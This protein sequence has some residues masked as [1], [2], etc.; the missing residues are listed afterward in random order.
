[1]AR[2]T[3]KSYPVV[4]RDVRLVRVSPNFVLAA[5]DLERLVLAV[6]PV[7]GD[8]ETAEHF[9]SERFLVQLIFI[10]AVA[11]VHALSALHAVEINTRAK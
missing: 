5:E 11:R 8:D 2:C 6:V 10:V 1:M 7:A 3:A 4:D 9:S